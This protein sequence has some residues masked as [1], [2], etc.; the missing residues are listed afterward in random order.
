MFSLLLAIDNR[1][2]VTVNYKPD[3]TVRR[4]TDDVC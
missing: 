2:A 4:L 3:L 1:E